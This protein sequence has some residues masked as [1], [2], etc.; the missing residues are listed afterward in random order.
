MVQYMY[1]IMNISHFTT[2]LPYSDLK[3][4]TDS[5]TS[6]L[7]LKQAGCGKME[8]HGPTYWQ[9]VLIGHP[10]GRPLTA[11]NSMPYRK[12]FFIWRNRRTGARYLYVGF[13]GG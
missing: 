5:G 4:K 3:H 6:T 7:P 9:N 1:S 10:C 11:S 2:L 13:T 8:F 12:R